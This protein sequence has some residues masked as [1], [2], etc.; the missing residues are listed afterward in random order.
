M[1]R[2]LEK[3]KTFNWKPNPCITVD[4]N[5]MD[6][7]LLITRSSNLKQ[8]SMACILARNDIAGEPSET[9]LSYF[10][11]RIISVATNMPL[12]KE[13]ESDIH[14]EVVAIGLAASEGYKTQNTSAYITMPP[15]RKCFG[16]LLCAGVKRI[17]SRY[18]SP[19]F[20]LAASHN[21]EMVALQDRDAQR[22]RTNAI[23]E[24]YEEPDNR[25]DSTI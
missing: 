4:E 9:S 18:D 8:G 5:F 3:Y 23:V 17:V 11:S 1:S 21:V 12:Y 13:N 25:G 22:Y 6:L 10:L 20:E 7:T 2:I 16:L 24:A 19:L 14:A 15:C